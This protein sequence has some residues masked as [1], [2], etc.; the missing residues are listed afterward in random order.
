MRGAAISA[1]AILLT[2]GPGAASGQP[3]RPPERE[4]VTYV[5]DGRV[6]LPA[7]TPATLSLTKVFLEDGSV[8]HESVELY[9]DAGFIRP[10]EASDRISVTLKWPGDHR[11]RGVPEPFSWA[12]GSIRINLFTQAA[13]RHERR[14]VW[15]QTVID[16][17]DRAMVY[18]HDGVRS[19]LPS[20]M[21][22]TLATPLDP[23]TNAGSVTA[24]I[25][26]LLAWGHDVE[27]L[28]VYFLYVQRRRYRPNEF[29]ND[30]VGR[31]RIAGQYQIEMAGFARR[32]AQVR[33]AA[34][35]W[36]RG[37]GDFHACRRQ[38]E[39]PDA[40][41]VVTDQRIARPSN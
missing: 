37:L 16:R 23:P 2:A 27:R 10:R 20:A 31:R 26:S 41:I 38:I 4:L 3:A 5:C 32:V 30:G 40:Q 15:Q 29:P 9:E 6:P 19:L 33:E 17:D 21:G 22:L 36:E 18:E 39:Y 25:D 1:L 14:E 24:S 11:F 8:H 7:P 12:D 34:T 28:T 35:Q 13:Y